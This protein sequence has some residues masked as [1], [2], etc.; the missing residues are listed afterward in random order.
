MKNKNDH[1]LRASARC[2]TG[3]RVA[4]AMACVAAC[5]GPQRGNPSSISTGGNPPPPPS[6]VKPDA[7]DPGASD[8]KR[9]VSVDEKK[10][11]DGAVIAFQQLDRASGWNDSTCRSSAERFQNVVR[12]HP[13]MVEAQFMVGLSYHRCNLLGDAEKAYQAAVAIKSNHGQSLSNLGEL[14]FRTGKLAEAKQYWDSAIKAN[15]KLIA[16]RNNLASMTLEQLRKLQAWSKEW[17]KLEEDA[18]FNLSNVLGVDS[19]NVKAY[20][21]Y[22]LVYMEGWQKNKNRLDL[23]KLLLD[24]GIKRNEKFAPLLNALGLYY[25]HR[26]QLSEALQRFQ[27]AVATD[28]SFV[29]A[30]MNVGLTTLGF[31]KYDTAKEQ[32]TEVLKIAPKNYDAYIGLG[33]ALRGL[34]DFDA[35]EQQYLAA[36]K[37]EPRRGEA[38]YNLGVLFKDFRA[39]KQDPEQSIAT[40]GKAKEYFK[41]FIDKG[42]VVED[43]KE[44]KEQIAL[45]DRTVAQNRRF[46]ESTK[47]QPPPAPT[48]APAAPAGN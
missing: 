39:T 42:G 9:E 16:A 43:I 12:S 45:I 20:T 22:G 14:Y 4:L 41:Q 7:G 37:L 17:Q 21:L 5:G 40:Y 23:A 10:D 38:F 35:A 44:A 24:E 32:F 11:Y 19:E 13:K 36:S 34:K 33:V 31:R 8:P 29:E 6:D 15:G 18:R 28:P 1:Q 3:W 27:A 48:P 2:S 46:I 26:N 25:M 30:R 47:N